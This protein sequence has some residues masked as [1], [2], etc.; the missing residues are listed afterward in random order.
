[1]AAGIIQK[2][3]FI[4]SKILKKTIKWLIFTHFSTFFDFVQKNL[5]LC[6]LL[7]QIKVILA[8]L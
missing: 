8:P 7:S 5:S 1:M 4:Y 6:V 3:F 2:A